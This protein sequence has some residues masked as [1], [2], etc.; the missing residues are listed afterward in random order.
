MIQIEKPQS[1]QEDTFKFNFTSSRS[2]ES[3]KEEMLRIQ[4]ERELLQKLM[5]EREKQKEEEIKNAK[6]TTETVQNE[7]RKKK[8]EE[9]KEAKEK[10]V[11]KKKQEREE[12]LKDFKS[13][14]ALKK[15]GSSESISSTT[16]SLSSISN[17]S[18]SSP[19]N[20]SDEE[21]AETRRRL[22]REAL[23]RR[24]KEDLLR[25]SQPQ[26]HEIPN[27]KPQP[28]QV[29]DTDASSHLRSL[30]QNVVRNL[31]NEGD[32]DFVFSETK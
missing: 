3:I 1:K 28:K 27:N 30:L 7:E 29:L 9:L 15:Q 2:E 17:S 23:S 8:K 16:S 31:K 4:K 5:V 14:L 6:S 10:L 26:S 22:M 20:S 11:E 12:K 32:D 19:K 18:T 24:V 21:D 25:Q 13:K